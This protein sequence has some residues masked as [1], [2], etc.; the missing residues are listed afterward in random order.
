MKNLICEPLT[1]KTFKKAVSMCLKHDPVNGLYNVKPYGMMPDWD[2][3]K[4]TDM[5]F[6]FHGASSFNA[7]LRKWDVS[8]VPKKLSFKNDTP[9]WNLPKPNFNNP[10]KNIKI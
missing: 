1:D 5:S 4:V 3:S 9:G 8:S 10:K 6:M 2:V 7:D